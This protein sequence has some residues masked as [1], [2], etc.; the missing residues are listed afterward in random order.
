MT[1]P[2]TRGEQRLFTAPFLLATAAVHFYFVSYFMSIVEVPRALE[3]EPS[4]VIG[5]VVGAHGLAGMA[6]RPLVGVMVDSG[7]RSRWVQIGAI[8]TLIAFIGYALGSG[9]WAMLGFRMLHGVAMG[10]FTT[11]LLAIVGSQL[12]DGRRGF[13]VGFYQSSNTLSAMYAAVLAV[14]L[15]DRLGFGV[16]F[17]FS[18]GAVFVALVFG[19]LAGDPRSGV[20][21]AV[22]VR[23]KQWISRSALTPAGVFLSMTATFNAIST[24]LPLFALERDLGN[25][26]L[27]YT[28]MA[29]GQL[30][31]RSTSGAL[32]DRF[33]RAAVVMPSLALGSV[34]MLLLSIV[35]SQTALLGVA[36]LYGIGMAGTQTAIVALIVDRTPETDL[37][38]AMA[39]Y[40]VAWDIGAL[41]GSVL[42]GVVALTTGFGGVFA[43]CAAFPLFGLALFGARLRG[44]ASSDVSRE[45]EA[46][47]S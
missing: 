12:P 8:G 24:F 27:F 47:G 40:S 43:I 19:V 29:V 6:T 31:T 46:A 28:L 25:V 30:A 38:S 39:T 15:I 22:S 34:A 33:G 35:E 21:D 41:I 14:L 9:P 7:H 10:L 4:W 32:S 11:A 37:G 23:P 13:G 45:V 42:L 5:L 2:R 44:A 16:A 1:A 26:G 18:A 17:G 20:I 3:D 36:V